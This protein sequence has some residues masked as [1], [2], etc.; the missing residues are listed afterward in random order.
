MLAIF[1]D[2]E[3]TGL[4]FFSHRSLDLAFKVIDLT[5]SNEIYCYQTIISQPDEVWNKRDLKSLEINGF[6]LKKMQQG[7]SEAEVK[8]QIIAIFQKLGIDRQNS[9]YICQNPAFDRG[10]FSQIIDVYTQEKLNWPYRWLDFA[11]MYWA[12]MAKN[13]KQ[14][15]QMI[16]FEIGLSKNEIAKFYHLPPEAEPHCAINGVNHLLLCY[17]TVIG[18]STPIDLDSQSHCTL[19]LYEED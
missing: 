6:D 13:A 14:Q 17:K 9:F 1:L 2:I 3:T 4:D 11:S 15:H 7:I 10:F 16:P 8:N 12:I 5:T 18:F 19:N